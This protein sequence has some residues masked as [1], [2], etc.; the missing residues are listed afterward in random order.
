MQ[1]G[2]SSQV[3]K[4]PGDVSEDEQDLECS[5]ERS[6]LLFLVRELDCV[7]QDWV[8]HFLFLGWVRAVVYSKLAAIQ[9]TLGTLGRV[10][11][12]VCGPHGLGLYG[13]CLGLWTGLLSWSECTV[14]AGDHIRRLMGL[15][16]LFSL[17]GGSG[18]KNSCLF[19]LL[20]L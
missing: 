13:A 12:A 1:A 19:L 18:P 10:P 2:S 4:A 11:A 7:Q 8:Q 17:C 14:Q 16:T 15:L 3:R 6:K 20:C 5:C 9:L